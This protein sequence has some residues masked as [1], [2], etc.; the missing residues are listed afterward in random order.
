M[1]TVRH[2]D[3]TENEWKK[4][5]SLATWKQSMKHE[6]DIWITSVFVFI[7]VL[8]LLSFLMNLPSWIITPHTAQTKVKPLGR[9]VL[10][11]IIFMWPANIYIT[12]AV[13]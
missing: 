5:E 6:D 7:F 8:N 12:I 1:K 13:S 11:V 4:P 3:W 10:F 9:N 2:K